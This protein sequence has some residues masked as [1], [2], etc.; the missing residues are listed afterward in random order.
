MWPPP[1]PDLSKRRKQRIE[2]PGPGWG[3]YLALPL[4][5][6]QQWIVFIPGAGATAAVWRRQIG[7]FRRVANLLFIELRGHG[8][9]PKPSSKIPYSF[10]LIAA[11]VLQCLDQEGI[12]RA[13]FVGLSLGCLIAE[14]IARMS[15]QRVESL[16]L[17]GGVARLDAW[18]STF[19]HLGTMSKRLL[20]Y[21]ALYRLFAWIIMPGPQHRPTRHLF[22]VQARRLTRPEY[23]RWYQLSASV[24]SLIEAN[25]RRL[26]AIPTL[27]VMG[28]QDYMFRR[29]AERRASLR[30]D[31]QIAVAEGAG[32]VC[33]W[34]QPERFNRIALE[35][36]DQLAHGGASSSNS[37]ALL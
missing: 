21:M 6:S 18:A 22:H 23:L 8:R 20:P 7:A 2:L 35:F 31:T 1:A 26:E 25:A 27:F 29:H 33:N 16:I 15:P 12:K 34:E 11:D 32:H 3:A 30:S 10:E 9:L 36:L 37:A 4:A 5:G 19:M 14:T 24:P 28:D 17:A 13:H